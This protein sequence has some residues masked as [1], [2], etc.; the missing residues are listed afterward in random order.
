MSQKV[1]AEMRRLFCVVEN[2]VGRSEKDRKALRSG[3]K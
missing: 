2:G 3:H 1:S